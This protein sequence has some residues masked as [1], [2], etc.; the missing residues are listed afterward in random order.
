MTFGLLYFKSVHFF[1]VL[2]GIS[3]VNRN[4]LLVISILFYSPGCYNSLL[5][6]VGG[7]RVLFVVHCPIS[8]VNI[9]TDE[10]LVISIFRTSCVVCEHNLL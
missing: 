4:T 3:K 7:G 6:Y 8:K 5:S 2:L 10:L 1:S 9:P